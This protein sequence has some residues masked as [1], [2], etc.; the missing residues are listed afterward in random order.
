M[1]TDLGGLLNTHLDLMKFYDY[2]VKQKSIPKPVRYL[3]QLGKYVYIFSK[4]NMS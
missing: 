3:E 4:I 2:E 1:G